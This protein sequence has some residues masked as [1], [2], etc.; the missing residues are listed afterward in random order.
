MQPYHKPPS[1]KVPATLPF[2]APAEEPGETY[3]IEIPPSSDV[4][5]LCF[6]LYQPDMAGQAHPS[7]G[8]ARVELASGAVLLV[9]IRPILDSSLLAGNA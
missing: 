6:E 9:G 4:R 2:P 8:Q 3:Q 1:D 7:R 5:L